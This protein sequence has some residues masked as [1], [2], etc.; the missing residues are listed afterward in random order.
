MPEMIIANA[1]QLDVS[2]AVPPTAS[3]ARLKISIVPAPGAVLVYT[4]G[5]SSSFQWSRRIKRGPAER[6]KAILP[7]CARCD[8]RSDR[9]PWLHRPPMKFAQTRPYADP[10]ATARKLIEIANSVE[11]VQ[12]GRIYIE[13][14][15][16][17]MLFELK[18]T[19][20]EYGAGLKLAIDRGWL[21]LDRSGTYVKFTQTGAELFA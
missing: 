14:I 8:R 6:S 10:E 18:A 3:H 2:A 20:V 12:D 19:P 21:T 4:Q 5:R 15:N 1:R 16:G 11:A 17:P 13:L 9:D 7:A